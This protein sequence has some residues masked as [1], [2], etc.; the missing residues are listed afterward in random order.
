MKNAIVGKEERY[1]R[2]LD[3]QIPGWPRL[4][5]TRYSAKGSRKRFLL[6][7]ETLPSAFYI[8]SDEYKTLI[9]IKIPFSG[10]IDSNYIRRKDFYFKS[11]GYKYVA[12]PTFKPTQR[13][14]RNNTRFVL[15]SQFSHS[16][17]ISI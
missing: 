17:F 3:Y 10:S 11:N 2:V 8:L 1:S 9:L 7:S 5:D 13:K 15:S 16:Q 14:K 6:L 12:A 4:L